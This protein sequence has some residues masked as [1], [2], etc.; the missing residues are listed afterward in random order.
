MQT[1][2]NLEIVY[3]FGQIGFCDE[4]GQYTIY[5]IYLY[6]NKATGTDS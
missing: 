5:S 4:I 6:V 1:H 2:Y 3:R